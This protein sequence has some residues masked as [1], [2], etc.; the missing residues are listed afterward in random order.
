MDALPSFY[1]DAQIAD[2]TIDADAS[3]KLTDE[4]R[5]HGKAELKPLAHT[6]PDE[7]VTVEFLEEVG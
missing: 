3:A 2:C 5:G 1:G 7:G 6:I 4:V